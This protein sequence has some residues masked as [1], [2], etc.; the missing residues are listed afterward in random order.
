MQENLELGKELGKVKFDNFSERYKMVIMNIYFQ[1]QWGHKCTWKSSNKE[2]KNIIDFI[3][4]HRI[5]TIKDI[6]CHKQS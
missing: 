5:S 6:T 4:A 3:I 1:K 2:T